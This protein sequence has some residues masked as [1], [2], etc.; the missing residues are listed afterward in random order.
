MIGYIRGCCRL[1]ARVRVSLVTKDGQHHRS[2]G[3]NEEGLC[4]LQ[5]V[6]SMANGHFV[7]CS[8]LS[9][10]HH[11][12]NAQELGTSWSGAFEIF[13]SKDPQGTGGAPTSISVITAPP[14]SV[15]VVLPTP[16]DNGASLTASAT[17]ASPSS[18]DASSTSSTTA[19]Q[20]G[21]PNNEAC[22]LSRSELL[23]RAGIIALPLIMLVHGIL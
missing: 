16:T 4:H 19:S 7:Q 20:T 2:R 17:S 12:V 6:L 1:P 13:N 9:L 10:R 5:Y 23:S 22:L 21:S 3:S 15:T 18:S 14:I 11:T 8:A